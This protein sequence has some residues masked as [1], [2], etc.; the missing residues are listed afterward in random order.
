MRMDK[1]A[2]YEYVDAKA[3]VKETEEDIQN[4]RKVSAVY[5]KVRGSNPEFPYQPQSFSVQG[6]VEED[7]DDEEEQILQERKLNA[8]RLKVKAEKAI[9]K[10]PVRMQRIIRF[11]IIQD[12]EWNEV[13][14]KMGGNCT[15]DSVRMEFQRWMKEK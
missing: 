4:N 13:A 10:A 5:D 1:K 2:I 3:L 8:K 12:L 9:N 14:E 11:K 7:L 6:I 15:G